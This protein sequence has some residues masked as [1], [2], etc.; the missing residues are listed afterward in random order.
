MAR[1]WIEVTM[2][3]NSKL[4]IETA[5][6]ALAEGEDPLMTP[7]AS[8]DGVVRR[9]E[10]LLK[11]SFTQI[12]NFSVISRC[13]SGSVSAVC[14]EEFELEFGVKFAADAG[15]VISSLSSEANVT[16]RMKWAKNEECQ[17]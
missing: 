14:P 6:P 12:K 9:T 15:I 16:I 3:D 13:S 4:Y 1:N 8:G 10:D 17:R 7:A 2:E 5:G 11:K